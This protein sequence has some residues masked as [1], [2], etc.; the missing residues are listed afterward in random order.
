MDGVID[1]MVPL[2]GCE[3]SRPYCG[4]DRSVFCLCFRLK[5][6]AQIQVRDVLVNGVR[7]L[8]TLIIWHMRL[9]CATDILA[10]EKGIYTTS[11]LISV[12]FIPFPSSERS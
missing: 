3:D 6:H 2:E 9:L 7:Q 12:Q 10:V 5:L 1:D 11:S 8:L 4:M